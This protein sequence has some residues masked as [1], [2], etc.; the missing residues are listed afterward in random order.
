V[1]A[2]FRP[3]AHS[4][5][6]LIRRSRSIPQLLSAKIQRARRHGAR[7]AEKRHVV[8]QLPVY[9]KVDAF[10]GRLIADVQSDGFL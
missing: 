5:I 3:L 6:R 1:H 7:M 8:E 4:P 2:P 10:Y 9:A